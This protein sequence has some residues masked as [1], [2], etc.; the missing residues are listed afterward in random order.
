MIFAPFLIWV[1]IK[2]FLLK[3]WLASLCIKLQEHLESAQDLVIEVF[4][5][6]YSII[7]A[8]IYLVSAGLGGEGC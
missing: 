8:H 6:L 7:Y 5:I 4:S 1:L 3:R 2:T